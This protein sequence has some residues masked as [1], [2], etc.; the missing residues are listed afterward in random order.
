MGYKDVF[1][2]IYFTT[3]IGFTIH[4]WISWKMKAIELEIKLKV[5]CPEALEKE[6][7]TDERC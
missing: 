6:G 4:K 5:W 1:L 2:L 3:C 7:K